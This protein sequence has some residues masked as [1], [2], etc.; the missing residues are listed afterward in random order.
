MVWRLTGFL[1]LLLTFTGNCQTEKQSDT[2][3]KFWIASLINDTTHEVITYYVTSDSITVK[4]GA[5][6]NFSGTDT[7]FLSLKLTN[8][9]KSD[10]IKIATT[11]ER[12]SFKSFYFNPCIIHGTSVEF[13]LRWNDL[14]KRTTLSNYYLEDVNPLIDFINDITPKKYDIPFDKG[15]LQSDLK[16]CG[17]NK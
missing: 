12:T 16:A 6:W 10:I 2:K 13:S 15:K 17:E 8:K 4:K 1:I 3:F 14:T 5:D 11:I 9:Q 7:I